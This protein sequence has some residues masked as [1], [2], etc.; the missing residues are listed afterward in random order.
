M[1]RAAFVAILIWCLAPLAS[2]QSPFDGT[3]KYD[4][5]TMEWI[6]QGKTHGEILLH[7]GFYDCQRCTP[8]FKVKADRTDQTISGTILGKT[9]YDTVN[10]NVPDDHNLEIKYKRNGVVVYVE[11][12]SVAADGNTSTMSWTYYNQPADGP[13][14]GTLTFTRVSA[15]PPG[16]HLINGEWRAV[17]VQTDAPVQTYL[18]KGNEVTRISRGAVEYTAKLDGS[19]APFSGDSQVD[20]VS[21]HLVDARRLEERMSYNGK[22]VLV[23]TLTVSQDGKSMEIV[24]VPTNGPITKIVARKQ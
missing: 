13:E 20:S 11:Q 1:K 24:N 10:V 4:L 9:K 12:R 16:T 5:S 7:D 17:Q 3:W 19:D 2:A 14:P 18:V 6:A 15:G 23:N 8:P 21:V 22:T